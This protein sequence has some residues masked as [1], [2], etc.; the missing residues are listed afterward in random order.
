MKAYAGQ[1]RQEKDGRWDD[2][3]TS[4]RS[5]SSLLEVPYDLP[6]MEAGQVVTVFEVS[7]GMVLARAF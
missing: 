4:L 3:H 1:Q 5:E 7:Q 6:A 2:S